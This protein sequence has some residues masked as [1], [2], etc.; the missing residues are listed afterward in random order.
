M[1]KI[2]IVGAGGLGRE[3]WN[4]LVQHPECG[5]L[6]EIVGFLDDNAQ[7]LDGFDYPVGIVGSVQGYLPQEN[8][9]L[10]CGIGTPEVKQQVFAQLVERGA[11]F[12]T[13]VHHTALVGRNVRL[14]QGCFLA[15]NVVITSDAELGDFV[16]L[17]CHTTCGHD[18]KIGSFT[19]LSSFCDLT[20]GVE[21]GAG[22]FLGSHASVVPGR[23]VGDGAFIGAGSVVAA[24]VKAGRKMFGVPAK[25]FMSES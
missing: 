19:T 16:T 18:V 21:L 11:S 20:G 23:K 2:L 3:A 17:N 14:G 12:H 5:V 24:H 4:Y 15:A 22:V 1:K 7:A 10:V 6:W 8:E 9:E 25:T 13:F